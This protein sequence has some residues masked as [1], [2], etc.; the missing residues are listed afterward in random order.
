MDRQVCS[1]YITSVEVMAK[2]CEGLIF[3]PL[4]DVLESYQGEDVG[5]T[6]VRGRHHLNFF[7]ERLEVFLH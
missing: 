2:R 1:L 4:V 6:S 7:Q 5:S 3:F